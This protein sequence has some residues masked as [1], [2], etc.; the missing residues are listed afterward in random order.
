MSRRAPNLL[1]I[2]SSAPF[3]ATLAD[4]L[5]DGRL[6]EG[7]AP[8][9]DPL[10]LASA[11]VFLPTRRAGR[12]L[13]E[14]LRARMAGGV[15]LLPRIVPLGDVDEDALAF[16]ES[17]TDPPRAVPPTTRRLALASLIRR[18]RRLL[19][20]DDGRVAVAAGPGAEFAL[21]DALAH[22]IDEMAAQE[23]PWER[24]DTL[25]PG[26]HDRYWDMALDFLKIA[27]DFWPAQLAELGAVDASVRRDRLI[28]AE[29]ARLAGL[30]DACPVIAAGSTGS[31]PAT[32]RLLAAVAHLPRGAVVLPGLDLHLDARSWDV[33][34]DDEAPAFSHPQYGLALLLR[35]YMRV[36]REAVRELAPPAP[37]GRER[38]LSEALR[39]VA[40]TEAW[41][42]LPERLGAEEI[43]AALAQ[44]G[45]IEADDA[46]E[47]ALAIAVALR[48][49]LEVPGRTAALI[50]PDRDL[51]RRVAAELLRFRVRID[52]S[53]GEPLSESVPGRFARLVADVCHEELAPVPLSALLRHVLARFGLERAALDAGA[54]ALEMMVLRG[55]RPAA[56]A[57]GLVDAVAAFSPSAYHPSDPRAGMDEDA[58]ARAAGLAGRIAGALAPLLALGQGEHAFG[59][60]LEAHRTAVQAAWS[61]PD[62]GAPE[63]ETALAELARAFDAMAEG[64]A[65]APA[66]TLADYAAALPLLL[67]DR[68]VRPPLLAGAR[69]RI[70]GPLEARLVS[71]DRVVLAGLVEQTWPA[72]VRTDPWLSRPMRAALGLEAPE[73]RTGLSAHDFVQGCGAPELILSHPRKLGG[74]PT[75]PS[76]F[77]QRLEAVSGE[78]RWQAAV[79]RG[80]R[81]RRLA[82]LIEEEPAAPRIARPEPAPPVELRPRRLS[83]TEIETWLRDPYTVYARHV[84][85]LRPLD[86]LDEAPGAAE[87]GT[88]I[89]EALGA[90]AEAFPEALPADPETVLLDY[91]RRAFRPLEAFP[92][93][94]ALWWARFERLVPRYIGWERSR[95]ALTRRVFAEQAG[96]MSLA[97]GRF[98]LTGRADRIE[99]LRAGGLA[100]VDFK[101]GA[102]PTAKQTAAHYSPQLP[103]EAAMAARGGFPD[104]PAEEA[105]ALVYVRL[106]TAELKEVS[107]VDRDETALGL[108]ASTLERLEG[109]VAAFENPSRG[110]ASLARPMFR[111]RFGDYDHLARV[112][113]WSTG[114][115]GEE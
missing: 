102:V 84:L 93:E 1:T 81:F 45:L 4:A 12:L 50:T 115:E 85:R 58:R 95:R 16:A 8:R 55:P 113:E 28:A 107:A 51:A 23:V 114:G 100:I 62:A 40:S 76:R 70:L 73:R 31:M 30:P 44:V 39:P 68:P 46:R 54:D 34:T 105:A 60:L 57:S 65:Q 110:Y 87:R 56:G 63:D 112:K 78:G 75:V 59:V 9:G 94:H 21:A 10:A 67:A 36:D 3:L 15:T 14:A 103:L 18:W 106:G 74:A 104:V 7:F 6:V 69:L 92:A 88:A 26:Q 72:A 98:T 20:G 37:Y 33:L 38:L 71:V 53:A 27:R 109:L 108:A 79:A 83:V 25:V 29:A 41:A 42:S 82:A 22:L 32:A 48:E 17:F 97:G 24:L 111:G 61:G 80:D 99:Q 64:A 77:L 89:H 13:G 5:L 90:F 86:R 101:T 91:G 52:D 66:M 47:E 11:T 35:R 19:A 96:R 43:D 49:V 2:P